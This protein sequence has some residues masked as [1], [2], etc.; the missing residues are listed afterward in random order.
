[1]MKE[2]NEITTTT[3]P[4]AVDSMNLEGNAK[5]DASHASSYNLTMRNL[6]VQGIADIS[7]FGKTQSP[8]ITVS[9]K[10]IQFHTARSTYYLQFY[11]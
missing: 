3:Q 11:F 2:D 7:S 9:F 4:L 6:R 1:M 8:T 5:S 10:T